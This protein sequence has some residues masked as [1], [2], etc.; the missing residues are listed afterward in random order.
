MS[1]QP[2]WEEP[3]VFTQLDPPRAARV[4]LHAG[5]LLLLSVA[6]DDDLV[7]LGTSEAQILSGIRT[8]AFLEPSEADL[9]VSIWQSGRQAGLSWLEPFTNLL[10]SLP[11]DSDD[12]WSSVLCSLWCLRHPVLPEHLLLGGPLNTRGN[13]LLE[14]FGSD[15]CIMDAQAAEHELASGIA[16]GSISTFENWALMAGAAV[17]GGLV[18]WFTAG[19]GNTL[20][21]RGLNWFTDRI[22][23]PNDWTLDL[24]LRFELATLLQRHASPRADLL[25][26]GL[27]NDAQHLSRIPSEARRVRMLLTAHSALTEKDTAPSGSVPTP[28]FEDVR[29]SDAVTMLNAL[30]IEPTLVDATGADRDVWDRSRWVVRAQWPASGADLNGECRLAFSRPHERIRGVQV[31]Q[32]L[33]SDR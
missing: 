6:S 19:G 16:A 3:T 18:G 31:D 20:Y 17:G 21:L 7:E 14:L 2:L 8:A 27:L 22:E 25:V 32:L 1:E 9:Y 23:R 5:H 15:I 28:D 26:Q 13:T 33:H 29:L 30:G 24:A 4:V 10:E 11:E 12:A